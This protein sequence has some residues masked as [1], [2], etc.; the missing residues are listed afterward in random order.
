MG[1]TTEKLNKLIATKAA[2]RQAIE[3][4]GVSVAPDTAFGNY[5]ASIEEIDTGNE[6]LNVPKVRYIDYDGTIL[7]EC[8]SKNFKPSLV[9]E[10]PIHSGLRFQGWN[11]D[12]YESFDNTRSY[13]VGAVYITE[14]GDTEIIIEINAAQADKNMSVALAISNPDTSCIIEWGDETSTNTAGTGR[15]VYD[16]TYLDFGRYKIRIRRIAGSGTYSIDG[17]STSNTGFGASTN[18]RKVISCHFGENVVRVGTYALNSCYSLTTVTIPREVANLEHSVFSACYSLYSV[19][20]PGG[21]TGIRDSTFNSCYSLTFIMIPES[22]ID[23]GN[24]S[25]YNCY[26]LKTI[27]IP[28]RVEYMRVNTFDSCY[29]LKSIVIPKGVKIIGAGLFRNCYSLSSIIIPENVESIAA[30]AFSNCYALT[31]IVIPEKVTDM[32]ASTFSNCYA[33]ASVILPEGLKSIGDNAFS[34]C[35]SL[36]FIEIP[37]GVEILGASVFSNCYSLSA[38]VVPEGVTDINP[39]AFNNCHSLASITVPEKVKNIGYNAFSIRYARAELTIFATTPPFLANA[40][41]MQNITSKIY[42]PDASIEAYKT[43]TNWSALAAYIY[44]LSQKTIY[45]DPV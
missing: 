39:S 25:F 7:M 45:T 9:P 17:V 44:P 13:D 31:S 30:N 37:K 4:K 24:N 18:A 38:I 32:A 22:V 16:K 3:S 8:V 36:A 20:L 40:I 43:A 34:G 27:V 23:T 1:T 29:A 12:L 11:Y 42:V 19:T 5:P 26:S 28:E 2:I 15:T 10:N 14:S 21:I 35:Y 41:T 33:L 6:P